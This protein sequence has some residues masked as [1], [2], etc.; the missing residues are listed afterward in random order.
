M[1]SEWLHAAGHQPA[2]Q[3]LAVVAGTFVLEDATTVVAA[4]EAQSGSVSV[5]LALGALYAGI[6]LGDVG[7]YGLGALSARVGWARRWV[8]PEGTRRARDWLSGRVFR[9]V[10]ASRFLPGTRLPVYTACGY[11]GADLKQFAL[12]AAVATLAWTSLLFAL[13]LAAGQF[14]LDHLGSWRWAGVV[15]LAA[16]VAVAGWAVAKIRTEE[17]PPGP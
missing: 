7:L 5:P 15:G 14:L 6:I 4:V 17:V 13:S 2:L 1:L 9:V 12:A 16:A 8:P 10:L 11:L 3:V